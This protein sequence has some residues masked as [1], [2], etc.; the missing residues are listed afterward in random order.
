MHRLRSSLVTI[1][2]NY[3]RYKKKENKYKSLN[4][5]LEK[6]YPQI[7]GIKSGDK[8]ISSENFDTEIPKII[9]NLENSYLYIQ[10]PPGTGKTYQAANAIIKLA[11]GKAKGVSS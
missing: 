11:S 10:G 8:I 6:K 9:S 3:R 4:N 2:I 7:K 5:F 1:N